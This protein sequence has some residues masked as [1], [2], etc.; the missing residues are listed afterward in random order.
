MRPASRMRKESGVPRLGLR[1]NRARGGFTLLELLTSLIVL[2]AA[3]TILLKMFMSSVT[4]AKT[5]ATHQIAAD[6]AEEYCTLLQTRPDLFAWPN[7]A[8]EKPG[9]PMAIKV[10]EGAPFAGAS[11]EPP[12]ALPLLRRAHD[13]E[14]G[15]YRDFTWKATGHLPSAE[16]QYIEVDVEV[17]WE[18]QG[19]LRQFVLA[20]AIPRALA[21]RAGQ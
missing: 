17:V 10:R 2:G 5:S 7:F 12:A 14:V 1:V 13:R 21:E 6:L 20:T 19:R 3:S 11:A 16:A 8:E 15:T 9:T 4:L 18:L